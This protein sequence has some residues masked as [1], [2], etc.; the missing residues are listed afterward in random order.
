MADTK[1]GEGS[2]RKYIIKIRENS[3]NS[4]N[5]LSQNIFKQFYGGISLNISNL[6]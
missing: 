6:T 3:P 4:L 1:N 2:G 5:I